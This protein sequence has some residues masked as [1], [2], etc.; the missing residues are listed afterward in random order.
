MKKNITHRLSE[1]ETGRLT[2]EQFNR[3]ALDPKRGKLKKVIPGVLAF[4][5]G[6]IPSIPRGYRGGVS[7]QILLQAAQVEGLGVIAT[8]VPILVCARSITLL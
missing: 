8:I 5:P 6:L 3:G 1:S 7:F 4:V 2:D